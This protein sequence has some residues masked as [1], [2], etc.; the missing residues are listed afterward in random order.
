MGNA[1]WY[2]GKSGDSMREF[3]IR[4]PP[5]DA[6]SPPW[7]HAH[8]G[9]GQ[10]AKERNV[11]ETRPVLN[12]VAYTIGFRETHARLPGCRIARK[13]FGGIEGKPQTTRAN[14]S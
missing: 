7:R 12:D 8:D 14:R 11:R 9:S 4:P 5:T 6:F 2:G 3:F 1:G 13:E 10:R